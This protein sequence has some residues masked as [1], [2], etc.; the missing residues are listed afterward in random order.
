MDD[1]ELLGTAK[2]AVQVLLERNI[3]VDYCACE[4][5]KLRN[6][7]CDQR[8]ECL[9]EWSDDKTSDTKL[10]A[11]MSLP[12]KDEVNN[13]VSQTACQCALYVGNTTR[14]FISKVWLGRNI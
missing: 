12:V 11:L 5:S 1:H 8:K 13:M 10:L 4:K 2:G 14:L 9:A 3:N 6:K 7:L